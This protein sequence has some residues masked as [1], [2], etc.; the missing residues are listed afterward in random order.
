MSSQVA[1]D[2]DHHHHLLNVLPWQYLRQADTAK[3]DRVTLQRNDVYYDSK[4]GK[5]CLQEVLSKKYPP[6]IKSH[7]FLDKKKCKIIW[8]D[9]IITHH[10]LEELQKSYDRWKQSQPE[11]RIFWT[12]MTE[13]KVRSDNLSLSFQDLIA[14]DGS[15]MKNALQALYEYGIL[16]VKDTPIDDDGGAGIAALG[17]SL[18]GGSIKTKSSSVLCNYQRGSHDQWMLPNGTDGP[19]RTLYGNV[20]ATSSQRQADGTS[21]ADSAYGNDGLPLHTDFTYYQDPPGLQIFTMVQP[22]L[23]GGESVF[24]DGFAVAQTLRET[25]PKAFDILTRTKRWYHSQDALTGWYLKA[26]GP[27]IQLEHGRIVGIRHNDL[28]RLPD[29]PPHDANTEEEIDAFYQDLEEAHW[30]WN[31]LLAQDKFR[32]VMKLEPGETMV[33]ANQ[34]SAVRYGEFASHHVL[35]LKLPSPILLQRCFHGRKSFKSTASHPRIVMGC[36]VSQEELSSRFR[37]EGYNII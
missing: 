7:H 34:V 33:V 6:Q 10:D 21:V 16:L 35:L 12:D 2:D 5:P 25:S 37:M 28:D 36:Y 30:A 8:S 32:L 17:A 29:L 19:M 22:A 23:E 26:S 24:G 9:N 11:D 20:W 27:V 3:F 31:S 1:S 15:G 14:R 4:T 13:E 18:G